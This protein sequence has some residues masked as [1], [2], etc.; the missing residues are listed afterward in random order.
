MA[1]R[2]SKL[3]APKIIYD[4][5]LGVDSDD[6]MDLTL[7]HNLMNNGD[8]ELIGVCASTSDTWSSGALGAINTSFARPNIPVGARTSGF[9]YAND[10]YGGAIIAVNSRWT[11]TVQNAT[12]LYRTLLAAA[13]DNSV[14]IIAAGPMGNISDLLNS[15]ADGISALNGVQL[16]RKK[17]REMVIPAGVY[18]SSASPHSHNFAV[19]PTTANNMAATATCP[20]VFVDDNIGLVE[21]AVPTPN[22][23]TFTGRLYGVIR[24]N[25]TVYVGWNRYNTTTGSS[26]RPCWAQNAIMYA[27]FGLT[28]GY[29]TFFSR[30]INGSVSI[31]AGTGATTWNTSPIKE[32]SYLTMSPLCSR[33]L[34]SDAIEGYLYGI[35]SRNNTRESE[36]RLFETLINKRGGTVNS[37][38][39]DILDVYTRAMKLAGVWS[40]IRVCW[41][42][43]GN[44]RT[45]LLSMLK[46][47]VGSLGLLIDPGIISSTDLTQANGLITTVNAVDSGMTPASPPA[48]TQADLCGSTSVHLSAY[49]RSNVP[50][51]GRGDVGTTSGGNSFLMYLSFSAGFPNTYFDSFNNS[52]GRADSGAANPTNA[53]YIGSRVSATDSRIYRNGVQVGATLGTAGGTFFNDANVFFGGQSAVLPTTRTY[54]CF[55]VGFGLTAAQA[56]AMH[57]ATQA[58][59]TSLGRNN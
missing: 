21:N 11:G 41:P 45:A 18:P 52:T 27:C 12:T 26:Y 33:D 49:C 34:L 2:F 58:M 54:A 48:S 59:Q 6:L 23:A 3:G 44:D 14:T 51:I 17:V 47:P 38:T 9:V 28:K 15:S 16:T 39:L 40:N 1:E 56:L 13:D 55:T 53:H 30:T 4:T 29:D 50:E 37:A 46:F 36:V 31:N 7:L 32:H 25:E 10:I 57:T 42:I 19:D 22:N 35:T 43:V 5:D 24:P 8:C 20:M